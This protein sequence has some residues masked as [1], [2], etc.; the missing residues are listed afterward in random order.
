MLGRSTWS[1]DRMSESVP[2]VDVEVAFHP[3]EAGGPAHPLLLADEYRPHFRV[4]NG[5]LLGVQFMAGPADPVAP[6]TGDVRATVRFPY[7]PLVNYNALVEGA[8]FEIV[9]GSRVVGYG[10]VIAYRPTQGAPNRAGKLY[11]VAAAFVIAGSVVFYVNIGYGAALTVVG[12]GIWAVYVLADG[13]SK[14][15]K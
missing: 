8:R 1:L 6:G 5:E 4:G 15:A 9:E 7:W 3:T 11:A 13:L 10:R 12:L 2:Y 14:R